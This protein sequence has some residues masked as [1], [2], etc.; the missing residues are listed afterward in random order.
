VGRQIINTEGATRTIA[1]RRI[2]AAVVL[3]VL[4]AAVVAAILYV[5]HGAVVVR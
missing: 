5:R 1:R 2:I 3:L 4:A